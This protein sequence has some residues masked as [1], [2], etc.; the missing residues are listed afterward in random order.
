MFRRQVWLRDS[1]QF[2]TKVVIT[3]LNDSQESANGS[4]TSEATAAAMGP[5]QWLGYAGALPVPGLALLMWLLPDLV[6]RL[7]SYAISYAA[8][9]LSFLGGIQWGLAIRQNTGHTVSRLVVSV[10]PSLWAWIA[11]FLPGTWPYFF[12]ISGLWALLSYERTR[13]EAQIPAWFTTLRL[14]LTILLSSGLALCWG[15]QVFLL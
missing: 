14:R 3:R 7:G 2:P 11:L 5:A 6:P 4:R 1:R 8:L 10:L 9:I 13:K 15:S 12:L